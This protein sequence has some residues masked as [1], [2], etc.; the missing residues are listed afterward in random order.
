[1]G[2]YIWGSKR[3]M[4]VRNSV[5]FLLDICGICMIYSVLNGREKLVILVVLVGVY[6]EF[7]VVVVYS[8][9][10]FCFLFLRLFGVIFLEVLG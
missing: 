3:G 7:F 9:F 10:V 2:I 1:M 6:G 8:R 5:L 4:W